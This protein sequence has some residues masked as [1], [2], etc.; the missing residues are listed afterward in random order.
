MQGGDRVWRELCWLPVDSFPRWFP[1]QGQCSS[2]GVML[3][4]EG[5]LLQLQSPGLSLGASHIGTLS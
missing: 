3:L 1:R 2:T 5:A 4:H